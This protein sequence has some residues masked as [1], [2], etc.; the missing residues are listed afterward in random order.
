MEFFLALFS[1][2]TVAFVLIRRFEQRLRT[3]RGPW[4]AE[5]ER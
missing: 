4:I 2:A 1:I 3:Q 5:I